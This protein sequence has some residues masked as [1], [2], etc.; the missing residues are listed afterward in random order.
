MSFPVHT[1][2]QYCQSATAGLAN[3]KDR[4]AAAPAAMTTNVDLIISLPHLLCCGP[5]ARTMRPWV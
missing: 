1:G 5:E 3:P 2:I 4:A